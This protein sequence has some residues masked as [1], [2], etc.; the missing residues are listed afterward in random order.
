[1]HTSIDWSLIRSCFLLQLSKI[2]WINQQQPAHLD[3]TLEVYAIRKPVYTQNLVKLASFTTDAYLV[4]RDN[5]PVFDTILDRD[6]FNTGVIARTSL[7]PM[8]RDRQK[9]SEILCPRYPGSGF[10][11]L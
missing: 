7:R 11:D 2:V 9:M 1:M 4:T 5:I 6:G 3:G 10:E 8:L